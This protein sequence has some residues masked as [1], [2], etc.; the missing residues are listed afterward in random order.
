MSSPQARKLSAREDAWPVRILLGG[1]DSPAALF[2]SVVG[3]QPRG[4]V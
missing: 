2:L 1:E 3:L 4:R